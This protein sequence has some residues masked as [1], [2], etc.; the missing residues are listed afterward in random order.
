LPRVTVTAETVGFV[1][2]EEDEQRAAHPESW[3]RQV[4]VGQKTD[5]SLVHAT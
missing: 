1:I 2:A 3:A 4:L 5:G